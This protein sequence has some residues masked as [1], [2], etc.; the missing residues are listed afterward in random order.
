MRHGPSPERNAWTREQ[1]LSAVVT[2]IKAEAEG[3]L[4]RIW[5]R[6]RLTLSSLFGRRK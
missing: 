3:L 6:L 4:T 2:E 5:L 1:F